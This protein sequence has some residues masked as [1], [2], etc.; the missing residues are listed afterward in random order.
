[1]SKMWEEI[2]EQPEAMERCRRD[3]S[4]VI[5]EIVKRIQQKKPHTVVFAGRGTSDHAGQYAKYLLEIY[6]GIPVALSSP[7]VLTEYSG[8]YDLSGCVVIAVSQSGMGQDVL[9]VLRAGNKAG[10]VTVGITN[11]ADSPIAK[12][13]GFHLFCSAGPELSVAATKTF[14]TQ[15]YLLYNL[16]AEWSQSPELLSYVDKIPGFV[17][18]TLALSEKIERDVVRFRFMQDVF[19]LS[20]GITLPIAMEASLKMNETS[21]TRA[22][23]FA[24]SDFYHGP[25]ALVDKGTPVMILSAEK[26]TK[27]DALKMLARLNGEVGAETISITTSP[28]VLEQSS[29][30]LLLPAECEGPASAF[31]LTAAIQMFAAK[32]AELKGYDPDNGRGLKKVTITR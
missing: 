21:Y 14:G 25:F 17:S 4:T 9:E 28:E 30:G 7:S 5:K 19:V 11:N 8:K 12:E 23:P 15:L 3:N 6:Q 20:R 27:E 22:R 31:A 2:F 18:D 29:C 1:M 24:I 13:A 26:A 32:L 16:V 10:A